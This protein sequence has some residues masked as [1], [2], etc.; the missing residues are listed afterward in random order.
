MSLRYE[1]YGKEFYH[2]AFLQNHVKTYNRVIDRI[3]C[4]ISKES[5]QPEQVT[6]NIKKLLHDC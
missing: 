5:N 3:L 6:K 2:C 1:E 4:E